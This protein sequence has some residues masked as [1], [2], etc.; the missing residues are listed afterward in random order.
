MRPDGL[1]GGRGNAGQQNYPAGIHRGK[2]P[3]RKPD[4]I[5]RPLGQSRDDDFMGGQERL[6]VGPKMIS[7]L[8]LKP[9]PGSSDEPEVSL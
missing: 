2:K 8:F 6:E 1:F 9:Q 4:S 7:P 5:F 3:G